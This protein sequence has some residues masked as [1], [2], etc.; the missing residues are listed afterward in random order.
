MLLFTKLLTEATAFAKAIGKRDKAVVDKL[1]DA[2]SMLESV[3]EDL[4]NCNETDGPADANMAAALGIIDSVI[5]TLSKGISPSD[6]EG[7]N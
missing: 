2:R 6:I 1:L 3:A 5:K 4:S 7:S